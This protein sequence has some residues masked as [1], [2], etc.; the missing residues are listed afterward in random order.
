MG[1][2]SIAWKDIT[3]KRERSLL[4]ILTHSLLVATGVNIFLISSVLSL[5]V[6]QATQMF[7]GS[8]IHIMGLYLTFLILFSLLASIISASVLS[9][10][11]AVSRMKD[12][13]IYQS[14]GGTFKQIQRI[15]ITEIFIITTLGGILG[16]IEGCVFGILLQSILR[17]SVFHL[18]LLD[19]SLFSLIFLFL[20]AV[21]TYFA[22][23]FIVN[24]LIRKKFGEILD[25][26]FYATPT[27]PKKVWGISTHKR[28]AFRLG[29]LLHSRARLVSRV[30]IV[31]IFVLT[32]ISSFGILGG[33]IIQ[34]TTDS[35][36]DRGYGG[37]NVL[38]ITPS[39]AFSNVVKNCYDPHEQLAFEHSLFPEDEFI[40]RSFMNELPESTVYESR[41]L[42]LGT[43]R[44]LEALREVNDVIK[45]VNS[46]FN[47]YIWGVDSTF[48]NIF[49][50]YSV[51]DSS[52]FPSNNNMF[53]G[54]GYHQFVIHEGVMKAI[55]KTVN[56][57]AIDLQRFEIRKVLMDP[58]AK[59]YCTYFHIN[60][61]SSLSGYINNTQ[62]NI[63]FLKN[64]SADII[65][66]VDFYD[67]DYF[68]LSTYKEIYQTFSNQ[69]WFI[70]NII[71]LPV[72]LSIGLSLVAFSALYIRLLEKDLY[73][74]RVLGGRLRVLKRIIIWINVF[75]G[76]QGVF[77][78]L[79][80]GF[81][82]SYT[83]LIPQPT[84]PSI[85][86]WIFLALSFI[87]IIL[88]VDRY[89]TRFIRSID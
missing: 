55:P 43:I 17:F 65:T 71:F 6:D 19:L 76:I 69:F 46:T 24:I 22:G 63:V 58:F 29:H 39:A 12:L 9:S 42:A 38:I 81:S 31:G 37:K 88:L 79:L 52:S 53:M 85:F 77:T 61:L 20:S 40:P 30:M 36:V 57:E 78:G 54:D 23:G 28:T 11:L 35:F 1:S 89:I 41:L 80:L 56:Q 70:S 5:Q 44:L 10:L 60:A 2:L 67:L 3:R 47:S 87:L 21:G 64:P 51:G 27:N 18:S 49:D 59:G 45:S 32:L 74:I 84:F 62:R 72:I 16:I 73:V 86:S 8:I 4:Y 33:S 48:S 15:P 83:L 66:L 13:A 7:N 26:Q 14:L 75:V 25:S 68:Y 82:A 50:Y 34:S